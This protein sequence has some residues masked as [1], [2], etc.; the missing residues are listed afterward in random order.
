MTDTAATDQLSSAVHAYERWAHPGTSMLA[1]AAL[2]GAGLSGENS[3]LD[4]CAGL[5]ALAVPAAEQGHRGVAIDVAPG[6]VR[7]AAERLSAYPGWSAEQMDALDLQFGSDEFDA[8]FSILGVVFFGP[9]VGQALAEM[10]RVVRPGGVLS[11]A[12]WTHPWG[13]PWIHPLGRAINRLDDPEVGSFPDYMT[14]FPQQPE[15]LEH[16]LSAAGCTDVRLG[17]ASGYFDLPDAE[18]FLAE[19]GPI[20]QVLPGFTA[21]TTKHSQRLGDL[22]REEVLAA[23]SRELVP[24]Q[25]LLAWARVPMS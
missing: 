7:R 24:S 11:L 9:K 6:M 16:V 25:G 17:S 20:C 12:I 22:V 19:L 8:A 14:Q 2:N 10:V 13:A 18:T 5:G 21:A 23:S 15:Q 1:R 4:V 3:V